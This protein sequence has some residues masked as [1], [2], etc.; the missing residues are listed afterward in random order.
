MRN[1]IIYLSFQKKKIN[2]KFKVKDFNSMWIIG[3]TT[4]AKLIKKNIGYVIISPD[5]VSRVRQNRACI[6][7]PQKS[8]IRYTIVHV[9]ATTSVIV[10]N[11]K[12]LGN[13]VLDINHF[14]FLFPIWLS[15][16][17]AAPCLNKFR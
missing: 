9:Y 6:H 8:P 7:P 15:C 10:Y 17:F 4:S 5:S 11:S 1:L 14:S 12:F 16:R 13:P 3:F 2:L